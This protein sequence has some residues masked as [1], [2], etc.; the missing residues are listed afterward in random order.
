[1]PKGAAPATQMASAALPPGAVVGS[2]GLPTMPFDLKF[3]GS[4]FHMSD[5]FGQVKVAEISNERGHNAAPVRPVN[6]IYRF[7]DS[8]EHSVMVRI[9][10][11]DCRL[12]SAPFDFEIDKAKSISPRIKAD[13]RG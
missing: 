2:A 4:F 11:R 6:G 12:Q 8:R 13:C 9:F 10:D 1:V 7:V 3:E 5:F